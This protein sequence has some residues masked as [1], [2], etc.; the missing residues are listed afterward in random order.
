[1]GGGMVEGA[2]TVAAGRKTP[3]R[4]E[5]DGRRTGRTISL[6]PTGSRHTQ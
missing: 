5:R 6:E 1:M 2:V 3:L 4:G